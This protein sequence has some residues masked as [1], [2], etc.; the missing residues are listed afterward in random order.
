MIRNIAIPFLF[1]LFITEI[2]FIFVIEIFMKKLSKIIENQ[3]N[4]FEILNFVF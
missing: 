3:F 2:L 4:E 1:V